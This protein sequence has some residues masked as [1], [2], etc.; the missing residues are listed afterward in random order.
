LRI[1]RSII[2]ISTHLRHRGNKI[3][4]CSI[5][6]LRRCCGLLLLCLLPWQGALA[7]DAVKL[8]D[9]GATAQAYLS[10]EQER[11]LGEAFMRSIRNTLPLVTDPEVD[12]YIQ[13]LG[14]RLL[15]N[16][17]FSGQK[18]TFFVVK[19]PVIN[20]FAGPG[21]HIGIHSGL[22]LITQSEAELA[23]VMAHEIAHVTQRHIAR[24]VEATAKMNLPMAAALI[25]A[26][27]LGRQDAKL[28]TAA[29]A[30]ATAGNIQKQI[31]FTR[32]N[33]KEADRI[34]VHILAAAGFDPRSMP[35]FFA[36]MQKASGAAENPQFEFLRTHPVTTSRIADTR[37]RA[38]QFPATP[39]AESLNYE[40]IKAK[41]EVFTAKDPQ[42]SVESFA[43]R[44]RNKA[45]APSLAQ[46]YGY[47][48][49][50]LRS[51]DH[52]AARA[53]AEKLVAEHPDKIAFQILLAQ[54]ELAGGDR[55]QALRRYQNQLSLNPLNQALTLLYAKAL[56]QSGEAQRAA[57]LLNEYLHQ[58]QASP[59]LYSLL[60][61]AENNAGHVISAH[62]A[63]AEFYYLN[64]E[65]SS[66][67][68]QLRIALR[69]ARDKGSARTAQ[70]E[71]RLKKLKELFLLEQEQK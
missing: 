26:I 5:A 33:E 49:A 31:N 61:Q 32:S 7:E 23:S 55:Q 48:L 1:C 50:L 15:A 54:T 35:L 9:I 3:I 51:G 71:V 34:G 60:A 20:A 59:L 40:L 18:F 37:N 56:V 17:D 12:D 25:T 38:E 21:G 52:E 70:I 47:A 43:A 19:S 24:A 27:V 8:P 44:L 45:Q 14:Y 10:S 53:T 2:V 64:G 58:R 4:A 11:R 30:A 65:T 6:N 36:R 42:H 39:A 22:I 63:L 16:S 13:N 69:T 57:N 46:R 68:N 62:Q 67:I 29:L 28:G 41:L 66:A